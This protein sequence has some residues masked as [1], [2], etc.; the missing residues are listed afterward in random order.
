MANDL[1]NTGEPESG[2]AY[3][4]SEVRAWRTERGMSQRE[5]GEAAQYGQQYVA[6]VEAGERLA[7]PEF[8]KACDATFGTPG[9][10]SRLRKR[11]ALQ[12]HPDWFEPYVE[13]EQRA[14][15]I[16]DYSSTFIM[17]LL[18]TEEYAHAIFRKMHPC[19]DLDVTAGKVARRL[20]RQE[21]MDG[22]NPPLL[23]VVLDE[24]CLRRRIGTR[25]VMAEQLAQLLEKGDP[26][27][28]HVVLQVLPF[29]SGTPAWH[30]PFNVMKFDGD[31]PDALYM[32]DLIAGQIF[33]S[34][35]HV[36]EAEMTYDLLRADA[37]SPEASLTLIREVMEEWKA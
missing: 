21:L 19:E 18:Q 24:S 35:D 31:E 11:A 4:G 15:M 13:L 33:G 14:S 23:W 27:H 20:K 8:A 29:E 28:P 5:L 26:M 16:L 25:R 1:G 12:K 37:L 22:T 34:P 32:E 36:A 10:F 9:T 6:K 3:F 7:S 30:T 2:A 17:G